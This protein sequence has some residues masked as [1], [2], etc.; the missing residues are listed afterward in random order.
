MTKDCYNYLLF[1]LNLRLTFSWKV[2]IQW[3]TVTKSGTLNLTKIIMSKFE[4]GIHER[5]VYF[6]GDFCGLYCPW[7]CWLTP[8]F[9][10]VPQYFIRIQFHYVLFKIIILIIIL[11]LFHTYIFFYVWILFSLFSK[12]CIILKTKGVMFFYFS[13]NLF[14][15]FSL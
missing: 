12:H 14:F 15:V 4:P 11:I 7:T 2:K 1:S 9:S 5:A 10:S 6:C 8:R 3:P 13:V